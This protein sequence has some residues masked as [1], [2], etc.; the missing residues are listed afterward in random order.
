[1]IC[2][3]TWFRGTNYGSLLQAYAL[4]E[5]LRSQGHDC[6]T[7]DYRPDRCTQWKNK[8]RNGSIR[9]TLEY[10]KNELALAAGGD[11]RREIQ[12][13]NRLFEEFRTRHMDITPVCRNG[14]QILRAGGKDAVFICGSDQIW[15][16]FHIDTKFLLDFSPD[17]ERNISYAASFGVEKIR[18]SKKGPYRRLLKGIGH[19]SVREPSGAEIVE[20]ITGKRPAV[21]T[22]PVLLLPEEKWKEFADKTHT[23]YILCYFLSRNTRYMKTAK[24]LSQKTGLPLLMVPMTA[25]DAGEKGV[26]KCFAG[27]QQWLG[28]IEGAGYV[29]TDSYHCTVF[30]V[31]FGKQFFV[32]RRFRS[33]SGRSQNGR[34]ECFLKAIG[35]EDRLLNPGKPAEPDPA[36]AERHKTAAEELGKKA[37]FSREWLDRAVL[38]AKTYKKEI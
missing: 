22:D 9:E 12:E 25:A 7:V 14:E 20:D 4:Q 16:P 29:L 11:V 31:M 38:K 23:D 10:K 8:L 33:G 30:S 15:N 26:I 32:L 2:I 36:G 34:I 1:M 27:P 3:L 17:K 28:L 6:V 18:E 13:R 37:A 19:I 24:E 21:V 35:M 5:Y